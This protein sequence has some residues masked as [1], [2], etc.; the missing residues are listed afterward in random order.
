MNALESLV[1]GIVEFAL[2]DFARR[3][4]VALVVHFVQREAD[5][6]GQRIQYLRHLLR[7]EIKIKN[8]EQRCARSESKRE[9][10]RFQD[11]RRIVS[12]EGIEITTAEV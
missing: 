6:L 12:N 3:E 11:N 10:K 1:V 5:F 9:I 2:G 8:C 4:E 7:T